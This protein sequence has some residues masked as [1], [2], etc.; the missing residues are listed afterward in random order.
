M[1]SRSPVI[2]AIHSGFVVLVCLG[3]LTGC[4]ELDPTDPN[5]GP[6]TG[7][8]VTDYE[9][10]VFD[11]T[12]SSESVIAGGIAV[13]AE[14]GDQHYVTLITSTAETDRFDRSLLPPDAGEFVNAVSF[15]S[16]LLVVM[17]TFPA[18]SVPD[19]RV[20]SIARDGPTLHVSI[21]DTVM[22]GPTTSPSRPSWCVS[23]V[24]RP[25]TLSLPLKTEIHS[26]L[27]AIGERLW[28]KPRGTHLAYL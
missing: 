20:E 28:I 11:L 23:P 26:K 27:A 15:E 17:Q 5:S 1:G 18:S 10:F 8:P 22:E 3:L 13:D 25:T 6:T 2:H 14:S 9:T 24:R 19:Y 12:P 7:T 16:E 4:V 21:N